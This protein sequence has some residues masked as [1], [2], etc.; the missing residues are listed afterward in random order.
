MK[1]S[2]AVLLHSFMV[3]IVVLFQLGLVAGLPMGEFAWGGGHPGRLPDPMRLAS[4]GSI[5]ILLFI[6]AIIL[7]HS[8]I[9]LPRLQRF[10]NSVRW[11]VVGYWALGVFLN[12]ITPSFWE[13]VI[14]VPVTALLFVSSFVIARK[15]RA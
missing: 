7:S 4:L 2:H 11:V 9:I 8:G 14:W 1:Q 13:R 3:F 6:E 12:L 5:A 10:A 15:S